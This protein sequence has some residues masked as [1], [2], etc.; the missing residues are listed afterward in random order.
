VAEVVV[1]RQQIEARA[2][3]L[4]ETLAVTDEDIGKAW[5]D[6]DVQFYLLQGIRL[7]AMGAI[8]LIESYRDGRGGQ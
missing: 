3:T 5:R 1:T 2:V 6:P 8:D 7:G 4:A